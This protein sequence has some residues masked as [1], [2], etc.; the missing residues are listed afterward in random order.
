MNKSH[1][2]SAAAGA[3]VTIVVYEG[4]A[5]IRGADDADTT[6]AAGQSAAFEA[7]GAPGAPVVK[8]VVRRAPTASTLP[9]GEDLA[10]EVA[11]HITALQDRI[12]ELELQTDLQRG[13]L[14]SHEGTP[15]EFPED[16]PPAY[17]PEGFEAAL[18]ESLG[19]DMPGEIVSVDCDE[20][21]CLAILRS[22]TDDDAWTAWMSDTSA[23]IED[24][25]LANDD[26]GL[27]MFHHNTK[28][29]DGTDVFLTGLA[30]TPGEGGDEDLGE[31]TRFRMMGQLKSFSADLS[32]DEAP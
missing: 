27:G 28:S 22:G 24:G 29:D 1:W 11:D 10:P 13:R 18:L 4:T 30:I 20:F 12:A 17:R 2:L 7:P 21:P 3:L 14:Q 32:E 8:R 5:T 16:L 9:A 23:R 25:P 6:L 31:R 26:L 19:E 15:Q